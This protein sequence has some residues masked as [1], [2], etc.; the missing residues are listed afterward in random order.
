ML[1]LS[2]CLSLGE[3][4]RHHGGELDRSVVDH[5]WFITN[6]LELLQQSR[7]ATSQGL[8]WKMGHPFQR[9]Q[10]F[11]QASWPFS[12]ENAF[13]V[14]F[15]SDLRKSSSTPSRSS[16][17][18]GPGT[19]LYSLHQWFSA[20]SDFDPPGNLCPCLGTYLIVTIWLRVCML[21]VST[22]ER[23]EML[24]SILQDPG[25][26]PTTKNYPGQ[27]LSLAL[28]LSNP[29]PDYIPSDFRMPTPPS[30]VWGIIRRNP[31]SLLI[32]I[33]TAAFWTKATS[34]EKDSVSPKENFEKNPSIWSLCSLFWLP[35][36]TC[37]QRSSQEASITLS[38]RAGSFNFLSSWS[39]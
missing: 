39:C 19:P 29:A 8:W 27:K 3:G 17:V 4:D 14:S 7:S 37:A 35:E 16:T 30:K 21:P 25:T 2:A 20:R 13:R 11:F 1:F 23:P 34:L 6:I 9:C 15:W 12:S 36:V 18:W 33:L 38:P 31:G 10:N 26:F 32:V 28:W 5:P 24:L 22:G